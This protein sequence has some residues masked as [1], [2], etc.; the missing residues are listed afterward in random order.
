MPEPAPAGEESCLDWLAEHA[1]DSPDV[2]A[3]LSLP[4]D[5]YL[6]GS[7]RQRLR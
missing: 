5:H 7:T 6:Y 2:P 4:H 3:D 1:V